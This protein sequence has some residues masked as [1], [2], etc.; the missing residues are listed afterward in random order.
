[1][2]K[3]SAEEYPYTNGRNI[4]MLLWKCTFAWLAGFNSK[5]KSVWFYGKPNTGKTT[6][7]QYFYEMYDG[8]N[9]T[10]KSG[11]THDGNY[12]LFRTT[13]KPHLLIMNEINAESLF[14]SQIDDMKTV[15][16]G[17]GM[18]VNKKHKALV[19]MFEGCGV[20]M[21]SNILPTFP[22]SMTLSQ[23]K[24]QWEA[25]CERVYFHY[26]GDSQDSSQ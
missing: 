5:K 6:L 22:K 4:L 20:Y 2:K 7:A 18:C 3:L 9:L 15:L 16:E 10:I 24:R 12:D 1:M 19:R 8:T 17:G 11:W 26:C 25:I 23:R 21:C 14:S 13:H